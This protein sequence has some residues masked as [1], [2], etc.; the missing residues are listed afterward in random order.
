MMNL[1]ILLAGLLALGL[2]CSEDD[3]AARPDSG[4][5]SLQLSFQ[6]LET[7]ANG[8]HYEG[9]A[10]VGGVPVSTGKFNIDSS[11]NL[12]DLNGGAIAG[13][14][15]SV[16][17]DL[18]NATAVVLTIE[19]AGDSDPDPAATHVLAGDLSSRE[20]V[21]QA[22]H[23]AALGSDFTASAGVYVLAT[24]TN[25]PETLENSGVWFLSLVGGS[26]AR[27][28]DLPALPAGWRYEGWMVM[29][30]TP[31]TTGT[32]T[33]PEA[34]DDDAPYSDVQAAPPFPG[35]DFLLNAP[36]ALTFPTDLAGTTAVISI[37]PDPD[38]SAAPFAF[39]P[40]VAPVPSSATDHV[41]YSMDN[42]A[43]G[44][45]TGMASIME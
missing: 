28:L 3:N 24:P 30:G 11:G 38:D 42:N 41:T 14:T 4:L 39:K 37:E 31:I 20:G 17:E 13:G 9:W 29:G 45:P 34:A 35:E 25:G 6:G 7:L 10:I 40:L 22:G 21:L 19:P 23:A 43:A 44:F 26:P 1:S 2:G 16:A 18:S 8:Y 15:F 5:H 27:G 33:D 12:V 32:F 36:D